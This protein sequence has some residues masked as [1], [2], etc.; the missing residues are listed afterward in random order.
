MVETT[1]F[2][3]ENRHVKVAMPSSH[4]S[5][6]EGTVILLAG[7]T[8]ARFHCSQTAIGFIEPKTTLVGFG[9]PDMTL[10]K[11]TIH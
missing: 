11:R 5:E 2:V 9:V 1:L 4:V 10:C 6:S 8:N 7:T 3:R